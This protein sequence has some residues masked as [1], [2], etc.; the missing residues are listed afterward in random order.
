MSHTHQV[1][2]FL[3]RA[4][5]SVGTHFLERCSEGV[6]EETTAA[7]GFRDCCDFLIACNSTELRSTAV[8]GIQHAN[9]IAALN[10]GLHRGEGHTRARQGTR[11]VDLRERDASGR[12]NF[13]S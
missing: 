13:T 5:S 10:G 7:D 1:E 2:R 12:V 9:C 3:A 8:Y 4:C 6:L 11:R